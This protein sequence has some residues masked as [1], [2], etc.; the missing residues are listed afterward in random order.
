MNC[1][2]IK[3]IQSM[4]I[5]LMEKLHTFLVDNNIKYYMIGGSALGA[6][7]HKGFI[8]WDDDIDLGMLRSDYEKFLTLA[9]KFDY[10]CEIVNFHIKKN[11]DYALTR[12]YFNNT[13][14]KND[15]ISSTKLDFRLFLDIF[16]IDN[17][18]DNINKKVK[19]EK[20]IAKYKRLIPVSYTHL[21][22]PTM[23]VV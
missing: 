14:I 19:T 6:I 17:V 20:K 23:A 10:N 22:L 2:D 7:R 18:A 1:L 12:I 13:F 8:P 15:S 5:S 21:T 3:Q 16:P 9:D 4:Q 11:C